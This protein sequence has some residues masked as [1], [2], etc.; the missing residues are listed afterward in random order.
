VHPRL[1]RA[2]RRRLQASPHPAAQASSLKPAQ[3]TAAHQ[4][5][6]VAVRA[7]GSNAC[8]EIEKRLE[9]RDVSTA[10]VLHDWELPLCRY[11]TGCRTSTSTLAGGSPRV[12]GPSLPVPAAGASEACFPSM[13][14]LPACYFPWGITVATI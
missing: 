1:R 3:Q 5:R 12:T 7:D 10:D 11:W 6:N 9:V 2:R 14:S 13:T 4:Y 8:V